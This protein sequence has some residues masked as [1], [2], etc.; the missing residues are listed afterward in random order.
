MM[1]Y[2]TGTRVA[3]LQPLWLFIGPL[4]E[5]LLAQMGTES[6]SAWGSPEIKVFVQVLALRVYLLCK[7]GK[8][9]LQGLNKG[10]NMAMIMLKK[11]HN[12]TQQK[13]WHNRL[14]RETRGF[15]IGFP[16]DRERK[17]V[18]CRDRG[19]V[20]EGRNLGK[21]IPMTH[22]SNKW[23]NCSKFSTVHQPVRS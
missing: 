3:S 12:G 21:E 17:H 7:L 1:M 10:A 5:P 6:Y 22:S 19:R 11:T 20:T 23:H 13:Q 14:W 16:F 8:M 18:E 4:L 2:K 15:R 9:D